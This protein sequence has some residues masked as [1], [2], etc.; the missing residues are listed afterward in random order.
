[1]KGHPHSQN[2]SLLAM[3]RHDELPF[4]HK[5]R[6]HDVKTRTMFIPANTAKLVPDAVFFQ[7]CCV[8]KSLD[9]LQFVRREYIISTLGYGTART[10]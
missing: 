1:M 10:C 9:A 6:S 8:S 5:T 2:S 3:G 7:C 4:S